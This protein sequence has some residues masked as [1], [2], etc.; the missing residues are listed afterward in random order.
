MIPMFALMLILILI[1]GI[2]RP[3]WAG[4]DWRWD[5]GDN[6]QRDVGECRSA[7]TRHGWGGGVDQQTFRAIMR[8]RG[9]Y[10][11]CDTCGEERWR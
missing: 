5:G 7:A 1:V 10:Q 8:G 3:H 6:F 2:A 9:W 11:V 4:H